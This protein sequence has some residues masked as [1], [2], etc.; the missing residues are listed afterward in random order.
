MPSCGTSSKLPG[1]NIFLICSSDAPAGRAAGGAAAGAGAAADATSTACS[2]PPRALA[3]STSASTMRPCGPEPL[4]PSNSRPA[5]LA[6]RRASGDANTRSPLGCGAA[7]G[8]VE[9]CGV[10]IA[11]CPSVAAAVVAGTDDGTGAAALPGAVTPAPP[12]PTVFGSSPSLAMMAINW[13]TGTSAVPSATK[14]LARM[15]SSMASTSIVA[16]SVSISAITSPDLIASPS[17]LSHLAR[18]PFSIVGDR[19]GIKTLTDMKRT[20]LRL[21]NCG[22]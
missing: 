5:S 7:P 22:R 16:L 12:A 2:A 17:F 11:V 3:V 15:P 18:L 13:L 6:T 9:L 4:M 8:G 10:A 21:R 19:A 14:I 1:S 20:F